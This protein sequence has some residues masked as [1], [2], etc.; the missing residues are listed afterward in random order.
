M[1]ELHTETDDPPGDKIFPEGPSNRP[2]TPH[3]AP[4]PGLTPRDVSRALG[5]SLECV[6]QR[7]VE[8][9]DPAS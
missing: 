4:Q 6:K 9:D 8:A 2:V 7:F 3:K 5:V 1:I